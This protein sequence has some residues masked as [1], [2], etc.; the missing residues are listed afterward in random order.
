VLAA[1]RRIHA[2]G[3]ADFTVAEI[4]GQ[5]QLAGTRYAQSTIDTHVRSRLCADAPDNH[6]TTYADLQR[7]G[8][9][10]YRLRKE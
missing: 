10:R 2:A 4:V 9:G 7:V 6:G 5:M 8:R 1:A 3:Q